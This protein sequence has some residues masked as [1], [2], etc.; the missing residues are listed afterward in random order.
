MVFNGCSAHAMNLLLKNA[1][2]LELFAEILKKAV[3][4]VT[5]VRASC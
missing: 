4:V 2:K 3:K 1:F 5:F